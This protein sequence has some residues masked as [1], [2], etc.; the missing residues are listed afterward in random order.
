MN[1]RQSGVNRLG[2]SQL[3]A[4]VS[5]FGRH[6]RA[7]PAHYGEIVEITV[8]DDAASEA[9]PKMEMSVDETRESEPVAAVYLFEA[10]RAQIR[11]DGNKTTVAHV[12]V[13]DWYVTQFRV[14]G[15]DIRVTHDKLAARREFP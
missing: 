15:D 10:G 7:E 4:D 2:D 9:A 12:H 5:I 6:H 14:H 13:G 8:G 11:T 1:C 3:G